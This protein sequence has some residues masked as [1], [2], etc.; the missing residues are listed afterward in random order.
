M[1]SP[2]EIVFQKQS[3]STR[4]RM[5]F[6]MGSLSWRYRRSL[7]QLVV[8]PWWLETVQAPA[9]AIMPQALTITPQGSM[10]MP[11]RSVIM[12][13]KWSHAKHHS[14]CRLESLSFWKSISEKDAGQSLVKAVNYCQGSQFCVYSQLGICYLLPETAVSHSANTALFDPICRE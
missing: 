8:A 13:R 4:F 7:R 5:E 14:E 6:S 11:Q 12:P 2:L 1:E 10:I 3:Y 9:S